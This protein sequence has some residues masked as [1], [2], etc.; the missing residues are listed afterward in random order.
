MKKVAPSVYKNKY[1][2]KFTFWIQEDG[3]VM[4]TGPLDYVVKG[5]SPGS[6]QIISIE[7]SGGPYLSFDMPANYVHQDA[8]K[9]KIVEFKPLNGGY[10]IVIE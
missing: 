3:N 9:G 1:G 7:P 6:N 4:M 5:F 10:L 8:G 2:A